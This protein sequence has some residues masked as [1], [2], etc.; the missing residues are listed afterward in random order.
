[1]KIVMTI[2][3][4]DVLKLEDLSENPDTKQDVKEVQDVVDMAIEYDEDYDFKIP[5]EYIAIAAIVMMVTLVAVLM[6]GRGL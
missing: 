1:M 6:W 2:A 5:V 4:M 3:G